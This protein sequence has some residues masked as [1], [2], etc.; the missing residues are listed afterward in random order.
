MK[1]RFVNKMLQGESVGSY[2]EIVDPLLLRAAKNWSKEL[3]VILKLRPY[4]FSS[5]Q[6][7][8]IGHRRS[9]GSEIVLWLM[10]CLLLLPTKRTE[11][12][13]SINDRSCGYNCTGAHLQ[14]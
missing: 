14:S 2:Q 12:N 7:S 4:K 1:C 9:R 10:H 13:S 11:V 3:K 5:Y 6:C 8:G